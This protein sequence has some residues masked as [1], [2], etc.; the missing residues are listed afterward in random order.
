MSTSPR[1][2]L[3][4]R[5]GLCKALD[6]AEDAIVYGGVDALGEGTRQALLDALERRGRGFDERLHSIPEM[7]DCGSTGEL[8]PVAGGD[9]VQAVM[10]APGAQRHGELRFLDGE[11]ILALTDDGPGG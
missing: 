8:L 10:G 7:R 3:S 4:A 11:L 2:F 1:R 6:L 5:V 9:L